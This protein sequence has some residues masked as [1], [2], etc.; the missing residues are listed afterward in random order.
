MMRPRIVL[1][2][3]H[4]LV[5]EAFKKHVE[6]EF[7]V[8]GTASNGRALLQV[9]LSLKPDVIVLDFSGAPRS[10][11]DTILTIRQRSAAPIL[12][13]CSPAHPLTEEYRIAG[14]ADCISPPVDILRLNQAIQKILRVTG[15]GGTRANKPPGKLTL[16]G[17]PQ[18]QHNVLVASRR[19]S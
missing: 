9:A 17:I 3:D 5:L 15:H 16:G 14:A 11:T 8:V 19:P 2:D 4:T 12:V 13:V 10:G 6:T 1:A 18:T 7:D